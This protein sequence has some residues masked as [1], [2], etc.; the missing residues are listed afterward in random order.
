MAGVQGYGGRENHTAIVFLT[1]FDASIQTAEEASL[2]LNSG[3]LL[4]RLELWLQRSKALTELTV[5]LITV[6]T[7]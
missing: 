4:Q 6:L 3:L 1:T 5:L 2:Y 7:K